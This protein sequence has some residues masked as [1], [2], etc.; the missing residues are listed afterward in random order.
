MSSWRDNTS[1]QAQADLDSLLEPCVD[2]ALGLL[3]EY[4]EFYPFAQAVTV[5]GETVGVA[6]DMD[7][8]N[9]SP[10]A[11]ANALID[12]LR[13][14]RDAYRAVGLVADISIP[15][16]GLDAVR[17]TTEHR[18]G[19]AI[20]TILRYE[21]P[22]LGELPLCGDATADPTD[23]MIWTDPEPGERDRAW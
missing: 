13:H 1:Q 11:V 7:V 6:V 18:E 5:E 10:D 12:V 22:R 9:P 14:H 20:T 2:M 21:L 8:T 23:P 3:A 4:G 15:D 16:A 17:I 19:V